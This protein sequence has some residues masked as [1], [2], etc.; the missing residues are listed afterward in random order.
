VD[1]PPPEVHLRQRACDSPVLGIGAAGWARGA[2]R[3]AT[4]GQFSAGVRAWAWFTRSL[5]VALQGQGFGSAGAGGGNGAGAF[6]AQGVRGWRR[7]E[8]VGQGQNNLFVLLSLL[9]SPP[10]LQAFHCDT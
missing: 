10:A 8:G 6:V 7:I 2:G 5:R 3:F 4:L 1:L 9:P